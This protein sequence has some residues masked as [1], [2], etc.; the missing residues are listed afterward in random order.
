MKKAQIKKTTHK[1]A[2]KTK[3]VNFTS[4][5]DWYKNHIEITES[6]I[7]TLIKARNDPKSPIDAT[8]KWGAFD[9][10][11]IFYVYKR[12][13]IPSQDGDGVWLS[14]GALEDSEYVYDIAGTINNWD[15]TLV[16]IDDLIKLKSDLTKSDSVVVTKTNPTKKL[17]IEIK[18]F[19]DGQCAYRVIE[20]V[21]VKQHSDA[22]NTFSIHEKSTY[23]KVA[24]GTTEA[25]IDAI[26]EQF[27]TQGTLSWGEE[28]EVSE[29][30]EMWTMR[31]LVGKHPIYEGYIVVHDLGLTDQ[32]EHWRYARPI[33]KKVEPT[34]D[35]DIYTWEM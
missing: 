34:I 16:E 9:E 12:K 14:V 4:G 10:N 26:Q 20:S 23:P 11:S 8:Y 27:V 33:V 17:V 6:L 3:K 35:G 21:G 5:I 29:E 28:C 32:P 19:S 7:R 25:L 24:H 1:A 2:V 22:A 15:E 30:K 18:K 31:M 13:P